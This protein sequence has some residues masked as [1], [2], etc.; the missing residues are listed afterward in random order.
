MRITLAL[1]TSLTVVM[2]LPAAP[3]KS[4]QCEYSLF[5][6]FNMAHNHDVNTGQLLFGSVIIPA[7]KLFGSGCAPAWAVGGDK[8]D[9]TPT[10]VPS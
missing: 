4:A 5:E 7:P 2:A 10:K 1:L 3:P 6:K 8:T 9:D